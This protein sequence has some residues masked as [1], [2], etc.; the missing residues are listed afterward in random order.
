MAIAGCASKRSR[1]LF[2]FQT[3]LRAWLRRACTICITS[4]L[5][6]KRIGRA[7]QK[8]PPGK[9]RAAA[10]VIMRRGSL[11][12][13]DSAPDLSLHRGDFFARSCADVAQRQIYIR[14]ASMNRGLM[15]S[16]SECCAINSGCARRFHAPVPLTLGCSF[17]G[18]SPPCLP[19][20]R[21]RFSLS[22]F[23]GSW[24]ARNF[25]LRNLRPRRRRWRQSDSRCRQERIDAR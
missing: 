5:I 22:S 9:L 10:R 11:T 6:T 12:L 4:P 18:A 25:R 24:C 3:G 23:S 8:L 1:F 19:G 20:C 16:R 21:F 13:A 15:I 14:V 17:F 2:I 7:K